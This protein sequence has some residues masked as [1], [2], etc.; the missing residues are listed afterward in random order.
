MADN[1]EIALRSSRA[2]A[3]IWDLV[4]IWR[5][6][7]RL[8]S[9]KNFGDLFNG[10]GFRPNSFFTCK[11]VMPQFPKFFAEVPHVLEC[12]EFGFSDGDNKRCFHGGDW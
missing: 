6:W 10:E 2:S 5:R 3:S 4:F 9:G 1:S 12:G 7:L 11:Y 8:G